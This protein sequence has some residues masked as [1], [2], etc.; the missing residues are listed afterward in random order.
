MVFAPVPPPSAWG[1]GGRPDVQRRKDFRDAAS[2]VRAPM[3]GAR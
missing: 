2:D 1:L 3:S